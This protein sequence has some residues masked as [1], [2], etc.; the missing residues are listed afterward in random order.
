MI[1]FR[2]DHL[3][4]YFKRVVKIYFGEVS[5]NNVADVVLTGDEVLSAGD[6]S[7][8]GLGLVTR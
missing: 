7:K 1:N 4:F 6:V 2:Y 8:D 5:M 3:F